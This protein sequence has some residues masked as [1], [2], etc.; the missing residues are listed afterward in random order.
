[1]KGQKRR[2][3]RDSFGTAPR[4]GC[5]DKAQRQRLDSETLFLLAESCCQSSLGPL[6]LKRRAS[7][8]PSRRS[9]CP[10]SLQR[11]KRLR[12]KHTR[13]IWRGW[14]GKQQVG[15]GFSQIK[16][17]PCAIIPFFET[18]CLRIRTSYSG[19]NV[20]KATASGET[21]GGTS[22]GITGEISGE[23]SREA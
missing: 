21:S 7:T 2:N 3:K 5:R 16:H 20:I 9:A 12:W 19:S 23:T 1:M 18:A 17:S 4:T 14:R 13:R 11:W 15:F 6:R 22:G 8:R 10:K